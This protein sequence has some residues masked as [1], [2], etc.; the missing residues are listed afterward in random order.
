MGILT[1]TEMDEME[2]F[3]CLGHSN[4]TICSPL[5][6]ICNEIVSTYFCLMIMDNCLWLTFIQGSTVHGKERTKNYVSHSGH[7]IQI[8]YSN[9]MI[10]IECNANASLFISAYSLRENTYEKLKT[11]G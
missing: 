8:H 2:D 11:I 3:Q 10:E 5:S 7:A 9:A 6:Q 4:W 1:T